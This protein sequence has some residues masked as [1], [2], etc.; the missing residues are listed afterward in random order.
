MAVWGK[1]TKYVLLLK[2]MVTCLICEN[3]T[4]HRQVAF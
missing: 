4:K 3:K 1:G 2:H